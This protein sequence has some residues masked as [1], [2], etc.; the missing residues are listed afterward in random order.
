M[1]RRWKGL[2]GSFRGGGERVSLQGGSTMGGSCETRELGWAG[3]G[4]PGYRLRRRPKPLGRQRAGW[5]PGQRSRQGPGK[6]PERC[7]V[8]GICKL[9]GLA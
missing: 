6:R 4:R 2:W 3:P 8:K 9:C 5:R 7:S 1:T